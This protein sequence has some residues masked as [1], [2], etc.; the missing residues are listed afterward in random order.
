LLNPFVASSFSGVEAVADSKCEQ[1]SL[2]GALRGTPVS[3]LLYFCDSS[4]EVVLDAPI[5]EDVWLEAGDPQRSTALLVVAG[6]A[7]V[8]INSG[9]IDN[10]RASS[11]LMVAD[12]AVVRLL[13]RSSVSGNQGLDG[14]GIYA[15]QNASVSLIDSRIDNST[16]V[17]SGGMLSLQTYG[18]GFVTMGSASVLMV[19]SSLSGNT[20]GFA[21]GWYSKQ[22]SKIVIRDSVVV[23]NTAAQVRGVSM[24]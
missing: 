1:R 17:G 2:G 11:A 14:V 13:S 24:H 6:Q 9:R 10:N 22:Y 5:V 3:A 23:N 16:A 7:R 20:N 15:A 4:A 18:G 19:G 8:T 12:Q 21:G